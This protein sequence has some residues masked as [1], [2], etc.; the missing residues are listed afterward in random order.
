VMFGNGSAKKNRDAGLSASLLDKTTFGIRPLWADLGVVCEM[1]VVG[2]G[3][4][5]VDPTLHDAA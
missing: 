5:E 3:T 1:Q 4:I 2:A